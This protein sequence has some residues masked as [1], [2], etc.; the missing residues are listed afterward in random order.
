MGTE[1]CLLGPLLVRCGGNL[2][3]V[4]QGKQRVVLAALLL[5]ANQV[6]SLDELIDTLWGTSPP[7]SARVT[8]RNHV[9][10]LRQTLGDTGRPR[11]ATRP[12]G[13]LISVPAG[14]LDVS[15][16]ESLLGSARAAAADG[17]WNAAAAQARAALAL[18]RGDPLADV[19][20]E[21]LVAR[22]G[23]RLAEL[24]LQALEVRI[25]ADLYLGRHGEVIAE[26]Q[27]LAGAH[28]L[29]EHLH[30][31]LML[32]LYRDGRQAEALA[33]YQQARQ[34]LAEELGTEP[35]TELRELHQQMLTGD[36]AL[37]AA[38]PGRAA[39]VAPASPQGPAAALPRQLPAAVAGFTG[40]A[41]ELAALTGMLDQAGTG[42]PG[43]VVIS[44][45]GGT[46][47]VG[48][49]AL[50]LRWAHQVAARFGDGQ[51]Y[52]NLRGFDPSGTPATPAE[53]IRGFLDA[54]G[55]PPGQIPPGPQAQ[56]GLYRS[57]L[58]GRQDADRGRQR[59]R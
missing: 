9:K 4:Q 36:P 55:V 11:I 37:A 3:P 52:V 19:P 22:E 10:R 31:L 12:S 26:L 6:V 23:P 49:T 30:A 51:L 46:A 50:A 38:Q 21:R 53:A 17:S 16:F 18:W 35:G 47:G 29:R 34:V 1:F 48:K 43:T 5:N 32:A 44:A 14:E 40:R 15:R 20:S 25:G 56:A 42:A 39:A 57:L 41:A 13:Y 2:I 54:L 7:P 27:R 24:R 45:I 59:P 8:A 28:P 58:A 33:A